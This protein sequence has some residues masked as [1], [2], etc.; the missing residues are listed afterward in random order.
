MRMGNAFVGHNNVEDIVLII[1]DRL[2]KA[3]G[4]TQFN[5]VE[6]NESRYFL[7]QKLPNKTYE[8]S[9]N[10]LENLRFVMSIH[11]HSV[12]YMNNLAHLLLDALEVEQYDVEVTSSDVKIIPKVNDNDLKDAYIIAS[13]INTVM[14]LIRNIYTDVKIINSSGLSIFDVIQSVAGLLLDG[15]VVRGK[16]HIRPQ[17]QSWLPLPCQYFL[18]SCTQ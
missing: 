3:I 11:N 18:T 14:I 4:S 13:S 7:K 5:D 12:A 10:D 17:V 6:F 1:K 16:L 15:S 8:I 9:L 2:K